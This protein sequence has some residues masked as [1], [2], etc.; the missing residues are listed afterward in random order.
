[1]THAQ[2]FE[3][4]TKGRY[5]NPELFEKT[6]GPNHFSLSHIAIIDRKYATVKYQITFIDQSKT[7][8]I[9][10]DAQYNGLRKS[11][12]WPL[13][14]YTGGLGYVKQIKIKLS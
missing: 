3:L 5:P 6:V 7:I 14:K 1:M 2:Q 10:R 4:K 12:W 8:V 9:M 11:S 13:I